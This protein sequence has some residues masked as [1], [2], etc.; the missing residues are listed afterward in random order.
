M[1][2]SHRNNNPE[3]NIME[4]CCNAQTG[5]EWNRCLRDVVTEPIYVQKV[6]DAALIQSNGLQTVNRQPFNPPFRSRPNI[7]R[8]E[9][10]RCKK[11]FN[12]NNISDSDNLTIVPTT[13]LTGAQFVKNGSANGDYKVCG[14]DGTLSER[15]IY[16]DTQFCDEVEKGTP[17]YGTQTIEISGCLVVE[18]DIVYLDQNGNENFRTLY[19]KI[20]VTGPSGGALELTNFFELC[21][22][23]VYDTAFL[24][25]FTEFCNLKCEARLATNSITRDIGV[26]DTRIESEEVTAECGHGHHPRRIRFNLII[27]LCI[28]CEKKIIVPVQLCVLSTG[29]PV[30]SPDTSQVCSSYPRLFPK[31]IDEGSNCRRLSA[32]N[33]DTIIE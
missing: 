18:I 7:I 28:T 21:M 20:D 2:I 9:D 13:T 23:S 3:R 1:N 29:Y 30:L 17:I 32:E 33:D 27:T 31:Q 11:Y 12:P 26:S 25:R 8:I 19:S 6:F 24:P 5:C 15:L 4:N 14:P 10:I 16:T 22:P